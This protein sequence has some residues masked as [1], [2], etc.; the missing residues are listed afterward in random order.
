MG[1]RVWSHTAKDAAAAFYL[2]GGRRWMGRAAAKAVSFNV[3]AGITQHTEKGKGL[4]SLSRTRD[5]N[6]QK[7]SKTRNRFPPYIYIYLYIL[8]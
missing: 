3:T 4:H 8:G 6:V 5:S 2:S 7:N 1:P